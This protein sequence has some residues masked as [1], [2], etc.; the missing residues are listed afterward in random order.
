MPIDEQQIL[1]HMQGRHVMGIYAMLE[2]E[3]C[4]LL[5]ADFDR[6]T[7]SSSMTPWSLTLTSGPFWPG[8]SG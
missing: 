2:D 6:G 4:R 8:F 3:T 7:P 1:R 5:A